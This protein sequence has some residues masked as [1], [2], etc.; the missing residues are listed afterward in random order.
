MGC[1]S[2]PRPSEVS[3]LAVRDGEA[4]SV[5]PESIGADTRRLERPAVGRALLHSFARTELVLPTSAHRSLARSYRRTQGLGREPFGTDTRL[6]RA[7]A[8][9]ASQD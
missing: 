5:G 2:G 1:G 6:E 7:N 9:R 3:D 8:A 4:R